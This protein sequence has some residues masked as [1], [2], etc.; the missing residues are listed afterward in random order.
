MNKGFTLIEL[1]AVIII[2]S[3]IATIT[4]LATGVIIK[5]TKERLSDK[6]KEKLIEAAKLY[7]LDNS[8]ASYVCVKTLIQQGY[9]DVEKVLD[10]KDKTELNG[11][12]TITKTTTTD[13][14]NQD[15]KYYKYSFSYS[16]SDS[17]LCGE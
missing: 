5:D 7:Q 6:Q 10:P 11:Y 8:N 16:N 12:I 4:L 9:L 1:L 15:K 17:T 13:P 3:I 14:D 2:L